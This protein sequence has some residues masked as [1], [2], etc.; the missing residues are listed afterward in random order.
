MVGRSR[1]PLFLMFQNYF[2][3]KLVT[4]V[5]PKHVLRSSTSYASDAALGSCFMNIVYCRVCCHAGIPCSGSTDPGATEPGE[6]VARGVLNPCSG[7]RRHGILGE[8]S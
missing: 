5:V 7:F 4:F 3:L 2:Q 8:A 6:A 1:T